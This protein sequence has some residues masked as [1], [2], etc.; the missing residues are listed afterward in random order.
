MFYPIIL[1]LLLVLTGQ[2]QAQPT[3]LE[4]LSNYHQTLQQSSFPLRWGYRQRTTTTGWFASEATIQMRYSP[5]GVWE[6]TLNSVAL[7]SDQFDI[8]ELDLG[9]AV[10][11][12]LQMT[13][14][15]TKSG[16]IQFV[17]KKITAVLAT[18]LD[19]NATPDTYQIQTMDLIDWQGISAYYLTLEP[20]ANGPLRG[21]WLDS[22]SFRLLRAQAT[23]SA[24]WGK[25]DVILDFERNRI[26]FPLLSTL[27]LD[28]KIDVGL[29]FERVTG[30]L[31]IE[32][33]FDQYKVNKGEN[34][35]LVDLP[36][37]NSKLPI[38][39]TPFELSIS[40]QNTTS[41]LGD[42]IAEY[43]RSKQGLSN[44]R[45]SIPI[46]LDLK[47]GSY[48]QRLLLFRLNPRNI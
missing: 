46:F 24:Y 43:N 2:V 38:E 12:N 41:L 10:A 28:A 6:A 30:T 29:L 15:T 16:E 36:T 45:D 39:K 17:P 27:S 9:R 44:F 13:S 25:A 8:G 31:K 18:S 4:V 23:V 22:Q 26:G 37:L 47:F 34:L 20:R 40:K 35:T 21:L 7:T 19:L 14:A 3:A 48:T 11:I 5:Q 1:A 33:L 42:R 32:Q